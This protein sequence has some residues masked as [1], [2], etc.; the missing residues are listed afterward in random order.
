M[1]LNMTQASSYNPA[2]VTANG[3]TIASAESA[4][5]AGILNGRAYLNIHTSMNPSGEIRG[6]IVPEPATLAL[7]LGGFA[8]AGLARRRRARR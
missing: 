4:L 6:Q 7:I 8:A 5:F 1:V 3:G 2:F